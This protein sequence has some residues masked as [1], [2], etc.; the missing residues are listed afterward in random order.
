MFATGNL[1]LN[2][3]NFNFELKYTKYKITHSWYWDMRDNINNGQ[4]IEMKDP[5][6]HRTECPSGLHTFIHNLT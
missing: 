6:L 5:N 4:P 2:N 3:K 1:Q